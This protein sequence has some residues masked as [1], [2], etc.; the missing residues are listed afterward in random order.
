MMAKTQTLK[1]SFAIGQS[2][3]RDGFASQNKSQR[4]KP[5][6]S[7]MMVAIVFLVSLQPDRDERPVLGDDH[8]FRS[9]VVEI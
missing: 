4:A 6:G 5:L 7:R 9:F 3:K 1:V 2:V 8:A